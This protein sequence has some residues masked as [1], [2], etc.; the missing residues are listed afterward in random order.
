MQVHNLLHKGEEEV[1]SHPPNPTVHHRDGTKGLIETK[2]WDNRPI[3][4][5]FQEWDNYPNRR[6]LP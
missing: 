3:V 6:V 2:E 1:P 4:P 5:P